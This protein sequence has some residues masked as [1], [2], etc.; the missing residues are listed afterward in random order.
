[1]PVSPRAQ[2]PGQRSNGTTDS[3]YFFGAGDR[4]VRGRRMPLTGSACLTCERSGSWACFGIDFQTQSLLP[5]GIQIRRSRWFREWGLS[6]ALRSPSP[7][8]RDASTADPSLSSLFPVRCPCKIAAV[9][10]N[11]LEIETS[12][13]STFS[14]RWGYRLAERLHW[15]CLIGLLATKAFPTT[16]DLWCNRI[17]HSVAGAA[18]RHEEQS[19]VF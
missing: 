19:T 18:R 9:C 5:A 15:A 3:G 16:N 17:T 4:C 10:R 7:L 12:H 1:M 6:E 11:F 14:G 8:N 2:E 13:L